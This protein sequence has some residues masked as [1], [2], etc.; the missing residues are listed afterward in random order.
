MPTIKRTKNGVSSEIMQVKKE[1]AELLEFK[2]IV[3]NKDN[4]RKSKQKPVHR[5]N[6]GAPRRRSPRRKMLFLTRK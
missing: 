2:R 5:K 6:V 3:E 4:K 1:N